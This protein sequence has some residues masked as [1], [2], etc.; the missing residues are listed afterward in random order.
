M[1]RI[2][3]PP[4]APRYTAGWRAML[5]DEMHVRFSRR[6]LIH[7]H[8]GQTMEL[9]HSELL[10]WCA[11][12]SGPKFHAVV[13]DPPYHLTSIQERYGAPG[14]AP[15]QHGTDG[16]FQRASAG[17]MGRTWD[18]GDVA[19]RSETWAA[20]A[21][22][23]L[24][25]G[26]ILAFA[27][28]RGAHRMAVAME[29][30]GLII[31]P[32]FY[33]HTTGEIVTTQD[34]GW[35]FGSGFPKATRL[36]VAIDRRAGAKRRTVGTKKHQPKFD[37]K[38]LGYRKKDNGFNRHDRESF[39][40]TEPAT[41]LAA[42]WA[43]HRYGGQAIK[44]ALEPIIV[45]QVPYLPGP[46][47]DSILETGAGAWNID[48]GRIG[49]EA[50]TVNRWQQGARV[51][52][53]RQDGDTFESVESS[54]RWPAHFLLQHAWDCLPDT[55][56]PGCPIPA[57]DQQSGQKST[58]NG[59]RRA[60][61][62]RETGAVYGKFGIDQEWQAYQDSGGASRYFFQGDWQA[63][64]MERLANANPAIYV[65]KCGSA[66]REAGL[67][68]RRPQTVDDGRQTPIDN[69]Y[70]RGEKQ[71]RNTHPTVKAIRLT[72]HLA[73]LLLP[74]PHVGERRI[75]VPFAGSGSEGIGAV[76]AGWD[77]VTMV[78]MTDEY[79]PINRQRCAY[80]M[81]NDMPPA[82]PRRGGDGEDEQ[83]EYTQLTM[84]F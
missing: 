12:Y 28:S 44:P 24:P 45:A 75:L 6:P 40:L 78:E 46:A 13:C 14:S 80:W 55:C 58:P 29:D 30:A 36:D 3:F 72:K 9:Y 22:H 73:D 43:G 68:R 63:E 71:R 42:A 34:L 16:L 66:E 11:W 10:R 62:P 20:I 56:A 17:F 39:D 57:L 7:Q 4:P 41:D 38:E 70:L 47:L 77:H 35:C 15:P 74:P 31:N 53:G 2:Q 27:S 81:R 52:G 23:V 83:D 51:F 79:I 8:G 25:G 19:F 37:A 48:A 33:N 76:K 61:K 59:S 26:F 82:L 5:A 21:R 67:E 84:D 60:A 49:N 64:V 18:G 50:I 65:P 1:K 32:T 69:A 54:G